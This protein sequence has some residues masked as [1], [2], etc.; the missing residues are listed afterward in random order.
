MKLSTVSTDEALN[1][2]CELTPYLANISADEELI[3]E[4]KS[5]IDTSECTTQAEMIALGLQKFTKIVPILLQKRKSDV[6]GIIGAINGKT[7][8]EI[9]SQNILITAKQ[10]RDI[11]KDKELLDFFKS[12]TVMEESE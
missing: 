11:V 8:E 3:E 5:A 10:I 7:A 4:L 12:C 9:A 2:L 1:I 6:H